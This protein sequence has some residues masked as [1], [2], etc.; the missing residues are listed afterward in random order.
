VEG[1]VPSVSQWVAELT[2]NLADL[3]WPSSDHV[4]LDRVAKL[5][6]HGCDEGFLKE[7]SFLYGYVAFASKKNAE[8][9][10]STS[11]DSRLTALPGL[12]MSRRKLANH[13]RDVRHVGRQIK[14]FLSVARKPGKDPQTL[15]DAAQLGRIPELLEQ[16]CKFAEEVGEACYIP[17][18]KPLQ[19]DRLLCS[20]VEYVKTVTGKPHWETLILLN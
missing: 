14:A 2:Q 15:L 19:Q 16:Y 17:K 4:V 18:E 7:I 12:S 9:E 11:S 10:R 6:S 1:R 3:A 20:L 8:A 5:V 13:I